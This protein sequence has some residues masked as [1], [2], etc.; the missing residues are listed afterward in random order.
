MKYERSA[1]VIVFWQ[2]EDGN[3]EYLLLDYG[4]HWDFPKG[5]LEKGETDESAA[6]RELLEETG[7][8]DATLLPGFKHEMT[9]FF[10]AN[11]DLVRK[12][13]VLFL[14]GVS[15]KAVQL[16]QEH[17]GSDWLGFAAARAKLTYS[18]ARQ[19][20]EGAEKFVCD[21]DRQAKKG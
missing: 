9:Y 20:L 14:A 17:S 4:R 1:G 15:N 2:G 18:S 12:T 5:H 19:A 21:G 7:I 8:A 10:R 16:S 3:R 11:T 13:V 6:L